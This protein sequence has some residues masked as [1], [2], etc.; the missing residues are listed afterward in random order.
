MTAAG[1]KEHTRSRILKGLCTEKTRTRAYSVTSSLINHPKKNIIHNKRTK[2]ILTSVTQG[3]RFVLIFALLGCKLTMK[4]IV[5][6]AK[7]HP[8]SFRA[9]LYTGYL[10][11][12]LWVEAIFSSWN[13][14]INNHITWCNCKNLGFNKPRVG[15]N[16]LCW[17]T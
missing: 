4:C 16:R 17:R 9:W 5:C 12:G 14:W 13:T 8:C 10:L 3:I 11:R 6:R 1:N 7:K 15:E 2:R